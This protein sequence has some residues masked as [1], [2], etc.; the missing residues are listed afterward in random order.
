[1]INNMNERDQE[2]LQLLYNLGGGRAYR[3]LPSYTCI[4][5]FI[6]LF[7]R[8]SQPKFIADGLPPQIGTGARD[9]T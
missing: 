3:S 4:K 7:V 6:P 1:M 5:E 9:R 8:D 2:A